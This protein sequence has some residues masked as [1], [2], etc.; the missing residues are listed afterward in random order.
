MTM[1]MEFQ[2]MTTLR[3]NSDKKFVQSVAI[4]GSK[5]RKQCQL[6]GQDYSSKI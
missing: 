6:E 5:Y 2:T 1:A 3:M 4:N